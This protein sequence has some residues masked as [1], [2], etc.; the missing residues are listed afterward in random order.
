MAE[1]SGVPDD[2][3]KRVEAL[4]KQQD[5]TPRRFMLEAIREKVEA[6]EVRLQFL[7]ELSAGLRG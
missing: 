2:L 3:K 5:T 6:E 1:T 4:A 7:A